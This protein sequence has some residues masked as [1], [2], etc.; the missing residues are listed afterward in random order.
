MDRN[1]ITK[2][3]GILGI[4]GNIFLF[5]IKIIVAFISG[6][7]AMI[8]DS[9]NSA[10]DV[11]ASFMTWLGNKIS[12]V[13][14]DEDHN[15]GHGKAEYIF[16]MLIGISMIIISFKL[17]YDSVLSIVNNNK[18]MF[19]WNLIII[20][21][22]TIVTKLF[23]YLYSKKAYLKTNNLLIKS[24]MIDHRNDMFLT[25]LTLIAILF[26]KIN[27][28]FIDGIVGIIISIWIFISG[29]KIF[30]ESYNV[31]MDQ[32]ID[33]E[34]KKEIL[35][36]IK[37]YRVIK[38]IGNFYSIPIGYKYIVIVTI[39]VNG[40]MKTKDSHKIADSIEEEILKKIDNIENV[41]VH[42]E[43]FERNFEKYVK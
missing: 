22:I 20:C 5:I 34:V 43:P 31:L 9:L 26:T 11:F 30:R 42:V 19:S 4:T 3:V 40:K 18:L 8:A 17:L 14:N 21:T 41:I 25:S 33:N 12:S 1:N 38:R 36:I 37:S 29:I 39:F 24:N 35:D 27:I 32:A 28:Y 13:P 15:Y 2:K 16:S 10:G 23:L 7:K 6:S